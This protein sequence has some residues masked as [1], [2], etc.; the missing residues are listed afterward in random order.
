MKALIATIIVFSL[1]L[2]MGWWLDQTRF[3]VA[4]NELEDLKIQADEARVS[5]LY[6]QTFKDS[7]TFC[8]NYEEE[9][10]AQLER[11][12]ALGTQ[13]T[14]LQKANKLDTSFYKIKKQ[15]ALFN[16]EFWM[17]VRNYNKQCNSPITTILYFYPENEECNECTLQA[18]ELSI[19]K[20]ECPDNVW[21]FALP[22]DLDLGIVNTLRRQYGVKT[23][24]AVV[25][26]GEGFEGFTSRQKLDAC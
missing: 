23:V 5:L 21:V 17:H 15:Y 9:L 11:V 18:T 26:N 6:F 3:A 1:G 20:K 12:G 16:A 22:V 24:P 4:Q 13:L 25:V 7:P 2:A 10:R 19:I 8:T 14:E